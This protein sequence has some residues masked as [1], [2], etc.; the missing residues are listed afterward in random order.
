MKTTLQKSLA[1]MRLPSD[2]LP[3]R[4]AQAREGSI[5]NHPEHDCLYDGDKLTS[6]ADCPFPLKTETFEV[7]SFGE[8]IRDD[9]PEKVAVVSY[10]KGCGHLAHDRI[11]FFE[12]VKDFSHYGTPFKG[13]DYKIANWQ[14]RIE[15]FRAHPCEVCKLAEHSAWLQTYSDTRLS[16]RKSLARFLL[17]MNANWTNWREF[18]S[19]AGFVKHAGLKNL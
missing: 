19:E 15:Y 10:H 6:L 14:A 12:H 4:T 9:G 7:L 3:I 1:A 17:L 11:G 16:G 2:S 18:I 5:C 8:R 13:D